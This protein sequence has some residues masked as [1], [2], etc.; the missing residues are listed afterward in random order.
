ML[1]FDRGVK[2]A[3]E[4]RNQLQAAKFGRRELAKLGLIAGSAYSPAVPRCAR[5]SP[6]TWRARAHA[7]AGP[8]PIPAAEEVQAPTPTTTPDHQYCASVSTDAAHSTTCGSG[9]ATTT[10][11]ATLPPARSGATAGVRRADHRR[12]LQPAVLPAD[13]ERAAGATTVGFGHPE[14]APH[15]HNFHTASES[16]GGPWNW[17][18]PGQPP[19]P[20]LQHG[21]GRVHD[22]QGPPSKEPGHGPAT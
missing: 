4:L 21:A 19:R 1:T 17:L 16:D 5:R 2:R 18:K 12:P 6:P 7:L 20:P 9:S 13:R 11:T 10:S 14:I 15:L 22:R 8:L 3:F